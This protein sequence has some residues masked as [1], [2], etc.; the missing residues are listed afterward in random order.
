MSP[1]RESREGAHFSWLSSQPRPRTPDKFPGTCFKEA[2]RT[3]CG[4]SPIRGQGPP[5][6]SGWATGLGP[7]HPELRP[8]APQSRL[9]R[10]ARLW[11]RAHL[12]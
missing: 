12:K 4:L 9:P 3:K 10:P 5:G 6:T 1:W 7:A 11:P 8:R 2:S